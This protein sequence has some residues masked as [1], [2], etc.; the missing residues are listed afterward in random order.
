[1][2]AYGAPTPFPDCLVAPTSMAA[3]HSA[4]RDGL[5]NA[6]LQPFFDSCRPR[7]VVRA[8]CSALE[9]RRAA[10]S[11]FRLRDAM[12]AGFRCNFSHELLRYLAYA[13]FRRTGA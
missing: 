9:T 2:K 13:G 1:S 11:P 4:G 10:G 6:D 5:G 8:L 3:G 7:G 12:V